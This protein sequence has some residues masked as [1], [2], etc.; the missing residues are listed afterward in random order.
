DRRLPWAHELLEALADDP[1]VGRI[2]REA[3]DR[4][5]GPGKHA[6]PQYTAAHRA[7]LV[8]VVQ[9]AAM[10]S[11]HHAPII[12]TIRGGHAVA[13]DHAHSVSGILKRRGRDLP[14]IRRIAE[15]ARELAGWVTKRCNL[16]QLVEA[17]LAPRDVG[18]LL[19]PGLDLAPV[20]PPVVAHVCGLAV[21]AIVRVIEDLIEVKPAQLDPATAHDGAAEANALVRAVAQ[22][23]PDYLGRL[24]RAHDRV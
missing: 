15:S 9:A 13:V 12:R 6:V 4:Q 18:H 8:V 17:L 10:D 11:D 5:R 3:H 21:A 19:K 24:R 16:G 7:A 14:V 2:R 22:H 1:L 23:S 20:H